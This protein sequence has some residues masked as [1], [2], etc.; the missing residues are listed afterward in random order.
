MSNLAVKKYTFLEYLEIETLSDIKHEYRDGYIYAMAG[1]SYEHNVIGGNTIKALGNALSNKEGDC[2]TLTS[3]MKVYIESINEAVFP[4]V[5]VLCDEPEFPRGT[6]S[7]ITNPSLIIEVLSDSTEAYDRG[8]KFHKYRQLPSFKEYVLIAQHEPKVEAFYR[9]DA[10]F[11][12][13]STA[14]G[15]ESSIHL[16]SI[17]CDIALKDI[18]AFLQFKGGVQTRLEL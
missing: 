14:I 12:R 5:S 18:Y 13:I 7:A 15:L 3:D 11:W 2:K 17:D 4:D 9:H 16:Y 1:G 6:R 10:S 8:S